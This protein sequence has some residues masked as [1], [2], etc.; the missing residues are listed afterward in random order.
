MPIQ[1]R[2]LWLSLPT[3]SPSPATRIGFFNLRRHVLVLLR[4][5]PL[6]LYLLHLFII[7]Q[8]L[9]IALALLLDF[10]SVA[11]TRRLVTF[12]RPVLLVNVDAIS[13]LAPGTINKNVRKLLLLNLLAINY[14][15]SILDLMLHSVPR[16]LLL[17]LLS[18]TSPL[19]LHKS[20]FLRVIYMHSL[21]NTNFKLVHSFPLSCLL[22][23]VVQLGTLILLVVIT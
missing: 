2:H 5:T 17:L 16:P 15:G 20:L 6:I 10:L 9:H 8:L 12:F 7:W 4:P 19:H 22:S 18:L 3:S 21:I 13:K 14:L 11:I 23:Q 1:P